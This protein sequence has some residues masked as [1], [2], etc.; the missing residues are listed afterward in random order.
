[1]PLNC[2]GLWLAV[3]MIPISTFKYLTANCT[4]GVGTVPTSISSIPLARKLDEIA[5]LMNGL[6]SR[7]SDP[8][9]T[10][11]PFFIVAAIAEPILMIKPGVMSSPI[12]PLIPLVPKYFLFIQLF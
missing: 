11:P 3:T 10:V 5:C 2:G 8:I 1:M 12:I 6:L 7:A 9:T 4:R